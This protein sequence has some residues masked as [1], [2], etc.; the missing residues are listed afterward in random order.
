M[1]EASDKVDIT[2][3]KQLGCPL[4]SKDYNNNKAVSG[5]NENQR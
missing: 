3:V 4:R 1:H 5:K 2:E